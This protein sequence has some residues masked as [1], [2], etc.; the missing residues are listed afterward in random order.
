[1]CRICPETEHIGHSTSDI[2]SQK[3]IDKLNNIKYNHN[4]ICDPMKP[5]KQNDIR[6]TIIC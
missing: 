6:N 2:S 4:W 3:P 5:N 1:M